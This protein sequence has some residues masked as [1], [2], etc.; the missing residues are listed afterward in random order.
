MEEK[1]AHTHRPAIV[2]AY[3]KVE[4]FT[5]IYSP[6]IKFLNVDEYT[7]LLTAVAQSLVN[8]GGEEGAEI[9]DTLLQKPLLACLDVL[10]ISETQARMLRLY[11]ILELYWVGKNLEMNST[12]MSLHTSLPS[13]TLL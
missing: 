7:D 1:K 3:E 9:A 12:W 13:G 10:K 11:P 5:H 4:K 8:G 2:D 6:Q